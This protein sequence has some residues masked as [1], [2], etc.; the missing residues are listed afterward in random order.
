[1]S[2]L[3]ALERALA[4][5]RRRVVLLF[6]RAAVRA[7]E[8][9]GGLRRLQVEL[10]RGEIRDGL[11]HFEPY[12]FT[13]RPFAGAEAAVAFV[14]GNRDHG[15]VLAVADRRYRLQGLEEGEV[16][17]YTDEG[18]VVHLHRGGHVEVRAA[19]KVTLNAPEVVVSG[20]LTVDGPIEA[21]GEITARA[22]AGPLEA[23]LSELKL[24]Y[25]AHTHAGDGVP[26]APLA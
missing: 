14:G 16:A 15:V 13:G 9:A 18:D 25:N 8:E 2:T 19:S 3:R 24:V 5:I 10:F 22:A 6:G 12:G 26:P 1:M 20:A 17:L 21:A 11:E 4:P 23:R 7:L